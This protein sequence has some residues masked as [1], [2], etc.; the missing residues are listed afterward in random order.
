MIGWIIAA[1]VAVVLLLLV[2]MLA[3]EAITRARDALEG[4]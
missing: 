3:V 1:A 4:D 2:A